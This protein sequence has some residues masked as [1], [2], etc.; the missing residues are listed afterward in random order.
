MVAMFVV[1][2]VDM[3]EFAAEPAGAFGLVPDALVGPGVIAD[4]AGR[5]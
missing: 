4:V 5:S 2:D 3:N 1:G